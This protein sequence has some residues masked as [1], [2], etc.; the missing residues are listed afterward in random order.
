MFVATQLVSRL[1]TSYC[2]DVCSSRC[3]RL[4][5]KLAM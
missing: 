2:R 3:S 1:L 4:A 5:R